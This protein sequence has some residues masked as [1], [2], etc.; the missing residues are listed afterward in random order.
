MTKETICLP[1]GFL[2]GGDWD[3][4][5]AICRVGQLDAFPDE[6]ADHPTESSRTFERVREARQGGRRAREGGRKAKEGGRKAGEGGQDRA[7]AICRVGQLDA[8]PDEDA[9]RCQEPER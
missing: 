4:A 5:E 7:E 6:D 8:F 9:D 1:L 2:H 3:R